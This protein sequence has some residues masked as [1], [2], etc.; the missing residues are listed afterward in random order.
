[1]IDLRTWRQFSVLARELHFGRAARRLHMTQPPL[2]LAMQKL[3]QA[4]GV[5]LFERSRR[6]VRLSAAGAA[7]LPQAEALLAQ[8]EALPAVARAAAAGISG[9]LRLGFVSTV[10]YGQMPQW[11]RQFRERFP[12]VALQLREATLD[13]QLEAFERDE[14]DAGFVIHA[15]GAAPAGFETLRLSE[16]PMV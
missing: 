14:L 12:E 4:L 2:S 15:P 9:R 6:S 11:L 3:E 8:A 5:T 13:V 1:M 10:G 7:L 16:E